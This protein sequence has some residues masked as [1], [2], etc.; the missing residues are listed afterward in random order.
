M[1]VRSSEDDLQESALL[2]HLVYREGTQWMRLAGDHFNLSEA[3]S[4]PQKHGVEDIF[5]IK[6]Q[7]QSTAVSQ[8]KRV[9]WH[10][11]NFRALSPK[12]ST[13]SHAIMARLG[14]QVNTHLHIAV[15]VPSMAAVA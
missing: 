11:L 2:F 10:H 9:Q 3:F 5:R 12:S 6:A 7:I 15:V 14:S 1:Q 8:G 4:W 13:S